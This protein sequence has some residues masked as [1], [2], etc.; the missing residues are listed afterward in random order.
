M[1]LRGAQTFNGERQTMKPRTV[2]TGGGERVTG[3]PPLGLGAGGVVG[4]AGV[5][6]DEVLRAEGTTEDRHGGQCGAV[7]AP[8][9]GAGRLAGRA[10]TDG[11]YSLLNS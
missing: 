10:W 8:P 9:R 4:K 3:E 1:G 7:R 2:G 5:L 6:E 11:R